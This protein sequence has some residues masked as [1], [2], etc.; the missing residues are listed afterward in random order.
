MPN[1]SRRSLALVILIALL[2]A[3]GGSPAVTPTLT[4]VPTDLPTATSIPATATPRPTDPPTATPIP[5]TLT[6][7][8]TA[9]SLPPTATQ[10]PVPTNTSTPK[11]TIAATV[12]PK[13][14][15]TKGAAAPVSTGGGVSSQP[16]TLQKSI[17]Q[18]FNAA[19]G[20]VS[21]LNE[22]ASGGGVEVCAPLIAEYQGI[23]N[24]PTYDV[25][26]QSTEMQNAYAAYRNGINIVN[27]LGAKILEL[28]PEWRAYWGF[29]PG[30]DATSYGPSGWVFRSG[31]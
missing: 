9:T 17:E 21:H 25:T 13:P 22:M 23:H 10:T 14:T 15:N 16:S 27:T 4:A 31:P 20:I 28:R 2:T 18:S 6:A 12:A 5:P 26:G 19:R 3:C 24:A 8:P 1:V 29:G 11:P 7:E 30:A